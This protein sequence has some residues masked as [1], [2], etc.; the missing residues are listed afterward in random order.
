MSAAMLFDSVPDPLGGVPVTALCASVFAEPHLRMR[1]LDTLRDHDAA[2]GSGYVPTLK[3][4][5]DTLGNVAASAE[6]LGIHVN[7]FRYRLRRIT[8]VSA[9]DLDDPDE[10]LTCS[11]EL[12]APAFVPVVTE[13][14][15]TH[16]EWRGLPVDAR[17][18][19][20][21][22][23]ILD[24][25]G[26][27]APARLARMVAMSWEAFRTSAWCDV[28][29]NTVYAVVPLGSTA[30]ADIAASTVRRV[31]REA[32]AA[33]GN[34]V[35]AGIGPVVTSRRE[36]ETSRRL[37]NDVLRVVARR[38]GDPVASL[39]EV[40]PAVVLDA[41]AT[42]AGSRLDVDGGVVTRLAAQDDARGTA[43]VETLRAY[44]AAFGDV[45]AAA[46]ATY[47]HVRTFR[48]RLR[49]IESFAGVRLDDPVT[50]LAIEL[51]LR[52]A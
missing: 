44:L 40:R 21:A 49:R 51:R 14:E 11:L 20:V 34:A 41:F 45:S 4:W 36:V 43:L 28:V 12:A 9:L 48:Y 33:L 3:A 22:F 50:R 52:L 19:A 27:E 2:H 1:Q 37:A 16:G 47:V 30:R 23:R 13:P 5:L 26:D 24:P 32:A 6:R 35:I 38:G 25:S 8:T 29:D 42:M 39:D 18:V 10:R 46:A 17:L 31:V 7:T 15:R